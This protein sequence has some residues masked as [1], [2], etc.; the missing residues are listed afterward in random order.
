MS[1]IFVSWGLPDAS[2]AKRIIKRLHDEGLKVGEYNTSMKGGDDILDWVRGEIRGA[3]IVLVLL[4]PKTKDRDWVRAELHLALEAKSRSEVERVIPVLMGGLTNEELP[5]TPDVQA[6][7]SFGFDPPPNEEKALLRLVEEVRSALGARAPLVVP[8]A[9]LAMTRD[10]FNDAIPPDAAGD[11]VLE[12]ICAKVGM[13]GHPALRQEL[14]RR[15][16]HTP[17]EFAPFGADPLIKLIE[18]A[19]EAA[20]HKRGHDGKSPIYLRWL[21]RQDFTDQKVRQ[22]WKRRYSFLIVDSISAFS[23][24]ISP[25]IQ[26]LPQMDPKNLAVVWV[27]PYTRHT[28]E[29]ETLI[30]ESLQAPSFLA[31]NFSSWRGEIDYPYLAFDVA[32]ATTLRRWV[33]QALESFNDEDRPDPRNLQLVTGA[34]ARAPM[35]PSTFHRSTG[36]GGA[37]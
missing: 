29:L 22:L 27:P 34:A 4:S 30:E 32:T 7:R 14:Q 26:K 1:D 6:V 28:V 25:L 17:E 36:P 11:A 15:Y 13:H 19:Q 12:S 23:P 2:I 33:V 10:E 9:L 18:A 3:C 16:G 5:Q 20:N 21:S 37:P 8:T 24:A 31:D 35:R